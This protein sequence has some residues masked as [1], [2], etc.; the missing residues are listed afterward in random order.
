MATV[1]TASLGQNPLK[2]ST[3]LERAE[4][5]ED[6]AVRRGIEILQKRHGDLAESD[7]DSDDGGR[8]KGRPREVEV[9]T[10]AQE[11]AEAIDT[12]VLETKAERKAREKAAARG[13][14]GRL[15]MP[16]RVGYLTAC[17]DTNRQADWNPKL[18]AKTEAESSDFDSSDDGNDSPSESEAEAEPKSK[19][20]E[21]EAETP[22]APATVGSALKAPAVGG[23]LKSSV[24]SALKPT[25]GS[26]IKAS[27]GSAL[28]PLSVGSALKSSDGAAFQ[29]RVVVRGPKKFAPARRR[30]EEEEESSSEE[31]SDEESDESEEGDD[32]SGSGDD[33]EESGDDEDDDESDEAEEKKPSK[34]FKAWAQQQMGTFEEKALMPDLLATAP[35]DGTVRPKK[36]SQPL[37]KTG[38]FVGPMGAT[39]VIPDTSLLTGEPGSTKRP[40]VARRP[41]V[42]E[43]RMGLPI[44]AEEQGIVESILMNPV[45][46]I[47]GETGSGKTTQVPQMLYEAGFGFKGSNNPGMIA[48]TQ[49][50]RVAAVSLAE[51]VRD[52]LGLDKRSGVVAHQIRYSSTTAPDTAIKFMT[53]GVL[54]RELAT[55]FLLSRYSVVVVDEA[56]E[57][58]VNTD[59]LIGVLSRVARLREKRWRESKDDKDRL[60]PLRIVIMS[61]TLRVAD[62]AENAALFPTPPPVIHIGARQ[63]PVTMHFSRRTTSDYVGEAF[64]KVC[65]IHARLPAG[66]ILVFLT[67]QSEIMGLCRRLEKKYGKNKDAKGAKKE[68]APRPAN[69]GMLAPEVLEAEDV[70]LGG[71]NDLAADVDD[72]VAEED[73]EALDTDDDEPELLL[74]ETDAPVTV[75]PLYSL[76]PQDQ[77]MQVFNPPPEG[78]RLI[79]VS[80][81]VAETSLTIPGVRYVVDCGRSKERQYDAASGVQTFAVSWISKASAAQRAGRAGRTG[82]GHCYRLYSSALFEDHMSAF[83]QPEILRMPIEG[84][85]LNMKAMNIDAVT[86]FP[87]PTPPDRQAL[88]RAES[89]LQHLGA[90]DKPAATRMVAGIT[91]SGVAGGRITDLG[92]AMASF[93]V[94]PRFAKM[95]VV[96]GQHD[97]LA[98]VIAIVAGLSVGD[99]FI[100]ENALDNGEEEDEDADELDP[101]RAAEIANI[102]SE[103]LRAKERRK[104]IR[105]KFF[106]RQ[107]AFN[108]KGESDMFKL[109]TAIG[110]YEH[111]PTG[112][113]CN[114]YFLRLK[115]MQEIQQLRSQISN[116]SKVTMKRMEP[117]N[118]KQVSGQGV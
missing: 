104:D 13:Q 53:D 6:R 84:V 58:G 31:D 21:P 93:P 12:T 26:A 10:T 94:S 80:T 115:A 49:P 62:F 100:H 11:D 107:S 97:C 117:P 61:A 5:I 72:G 56:H 45:V 118:D 86:N 57:R 8:T 20:P 60:S 2:P 28:K 44:L 64:N 39:L 110:A 63:H 14:S 79:I 52:E 81:N 78:H 32:E 101:E 87:F 1:S 29:P 18:K 85:V 74:E 95:L 17:T 50:R 99:P 98:Y 113:F 82:P 91:K 54:L 38:E 105:G 68:V 25:V 22:K 109:L 55:D 37:P 77:Q 30:A 16:K 76:L 83:S 116:I 59:V 92:R 90:L 35:A 106:K 73:P 71:D 96:G 23:A 114:E 40:K 41:S 34:G 46:V 36:V 27:I 70:D 47:C 69:D 42:V 112:T 89:L 65:K 103:E 75:L 88:K 43:S 4:R 7:S 67:G 24:G 108:G 48:V 15:Q 3:A 33:D 66:A 19:S 9:V 51:R 102:R 111:N